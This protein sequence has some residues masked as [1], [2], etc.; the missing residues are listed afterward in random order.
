MKTDALLTPPHLIYF[1]LQTFIIGS[2][3]LFNL[4]LKPK[5][6]LMRPKKFIYIIVVPFQINLQYIKQ[7]FNNLEGRKMR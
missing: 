5:V 2:H 3:E 6:H 4:R 1:S 7:V